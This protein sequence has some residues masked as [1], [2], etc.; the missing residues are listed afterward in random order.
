MFLNAMPCLNKTALCLLYLLAFLS[1]P[2]TAADRLEVEIRP[3]VL[4]VRQTTSTTSPVVAVLQQ[5]ERITVTTTGL[6]DWIK[7]D[8]RRGFISIH[9]VNVLSRTPVLQSPAE[10]IIDQ[11]NSKQATPE[12][13]VI[14]ETETSE[15]AGESVAI[16]R[17]YVPAKSADVPALCSANR[18]NTQI[19]L[20][21]QSKTC[22]KN[23][24]TMGYE[25]CEILLNFS[26]NSE[27]TTP[28]RINVQCTANIVSQGTGLIQKQ[29]ELSI[30]KL[31]PV[32]ES[33]TSSLR[34]SWAPQD[35]DVPVSQIQISDGNCQ[36]TVR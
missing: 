32:T 26:L 6:Q 19:E 2:A 14:P 24:L 28:S 7:L 4:N 29:T 35:P 27:C 1:G 11:S 9:Y 18:N 33:G 22:R 36:L 31:I 25:S 15:L 12:A 20:T 13:E 10:Q 23:L 34:L 8:D 5:G 30:Q 3:S 21:G 17:A 16:K